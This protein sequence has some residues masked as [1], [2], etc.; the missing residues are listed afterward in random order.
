MRYALSFCLTLSLAGCMATGVKVQE[1]QLDQFLRGTTTY[2]EVVH[3]LG[4]PTST[5]RHANGARDV[6]YAYTQIQASPLNFVPLAGA[7]LGGMTSEHSAVTIAFDPAGRFVDYTTTHGS[8][9]MGTGISSG[10]RQ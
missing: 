4:P 7:F 9:V 6:V 10:A 5:T 1:A 8:D 2:A 3:A